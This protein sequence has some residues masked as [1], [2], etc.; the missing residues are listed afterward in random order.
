MLTLAMQND[1]SLST[2]VVLSVSNKS[3]SNGIYCLITLAY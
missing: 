2:V 3:I 1:V